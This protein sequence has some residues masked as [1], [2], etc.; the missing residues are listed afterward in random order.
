[1]SEVSTEPVVG[2]L[3]SVTHR[4]FIAK[5]QHLFRHSLVAK[6]SEVSTELVDFWIWSAADYPNHFP[7]STIISFIYVR[8][9]DIFYSPFFCQLRKAFIVFGL[10]MNSHQ[11]AW[12]LKLYK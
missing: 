11:I 5:K 12:N 9:I 2:T 1:M 7:P 4:I 8:F 10:E 6:M 3:G